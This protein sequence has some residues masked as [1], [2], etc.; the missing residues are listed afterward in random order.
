MGLVSEECNVFLGLG[1][2]Y[3]Y[4]FR[5]HMSLNDIVKLGCSSMLCNA[6]RNT[7]MNTDFAGMTGTLCC[8]N[9]RHYCNSSG[10]G[11]CLVPFV[12][13][14]LLLLTVYVQIIDN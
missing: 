2:S 5:E 1:E 8:C 6:L 14:L 3:C 10:R 7:C 9:D 13:P 11:T 12:I 4:T